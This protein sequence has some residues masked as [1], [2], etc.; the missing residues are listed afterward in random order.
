M[1]TLEKRPVWRVGN[2]GG[3]EAVRSRDSATCLRGFWPHSP[4]QGAS[5]VLRAWY[6]RCLDPAAM[7]SAKQL[8]AAEHDQQIANDQGADFGS[9]QRWRIGGFQVGLLRGPSDNR[10]RLE[11]ELRH[12]GYAL[13]LP[14][15]LSWAESQRRPSDHWLMFIQ[16]TA[17]RPCGAV[18]VHVSPSRA[19]PGHRL[20][21]VERFGPGIQ[22]AAYAATL[23]ALIALARR[24]PRVLRVYVESFAFDPNVRTALESVLASA[25]FVRL[26]SP[27]CYEQTLVLP[28]DKDEE[29][30]LAGFH[31]TARQNIR[32]SWKQPL[33][34]APVV[35]PAHFDR[36]DEIAAETFARTGGRYVPVFDW[37]RIAAVGEREPET[38]RLVGL[39]HTEKEGPASLLAFAWGCGH[40]DHVHYSFSGSTRNTDRRIP[41]L[42][43]LLWD[44][45][46]WAKR[47]GARVFDFGGVT[48]GSMTSGDPLGGIS[49]F[50][51][52][53]TSTQLQVGA[54]W[55]Y[56]PR[57]GRA[58]A[59][60][61]MKSA[62]TKLSR[63]LVRA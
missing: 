49:D 40:G 32:N 37:A 4:A 44:L 30:I 2:T 60:R 27:R 16:D 59:A 12:A 8:T 47:S 14:H 22:A 20:L 45:I 33:R 1:K 18:G 17:G 21:R 50:K 36:L 52:Y 63:M 25:G 42:Y 48:A 51:R 46:L 35:H 3:P 62:A 6:G 55:S 61:M 41:L 34:L 13:P 57:P 31:R 23:Q 5:E 58:H 10:S 43:P 24:D 54:E 56:E 26:A 19:L 39:F 11:R 15:R 7:P 29:S 53:F 38:S 28:L 9:H